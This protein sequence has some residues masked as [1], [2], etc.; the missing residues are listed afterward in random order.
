MVSTNIP[1][2]T[3]GSIH[4]VEVL[5]RRRMISWSPVLGARTR[6]VPACE[7]LHL[8]LPSRAV[9]V[10]IGST[11][12]N[13]RA[14]DGR[15][16]KSVKTVNTRSETAFRATHRH[17]SKSSLTGFHPVSR[18]I[19]TSASV[20]AT[21]SVCPRQHSGSGIYKFLLVHIARNRWPEWD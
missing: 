2:R 16:Q 14:G 11:Q 17:M 3:G 1:C 5:H 19:H 12:F 8:V 13:P 4:G 20:F 21:H 7:T 10:G 15:P 9:I 6:S 18:R